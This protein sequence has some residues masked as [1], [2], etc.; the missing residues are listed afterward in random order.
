[1][2]RIKSDLLVLGSGIAGLTFAIKAARRFPDR[3][4]LML[5]KTVEGESNTRYA[6]GGVAPYGMAKKIISRS[7]LPTRWMPGMGFARRKSCV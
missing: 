2:T 4:I 7:I 3:H 6:Q 1:M 5:T